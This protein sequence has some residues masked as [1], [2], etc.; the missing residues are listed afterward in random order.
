MQA[1]T[2]SLYISEPLA[3]QRSLV[4]DNCKQC[5]LCVKECRFLSEYGNPAQIAASYSEMQ[6][7][8]AFEC[9][10]C[11][12]CTAVCP[13]DV[14]P[15]KMFLEMRRETTR[16][17]GGIPPTYKIIRNYEKRG[18]SPRFSYYGLPEGCNTIFF[19]GCSLPGTR[20]DK[21]I[22]LFQYLQ[23]RTPGIGIVLDCCTK[24][25]HDL[26]DE[27]FFENMF[28][29]L[30]RYLLDHNIS[31]VIVACTNCY[32]VFKNYGDEL[33]VISAYE[34]LDRDFLPPVINNKAPITIHDPCAVRFDATIHTAVRSL[35]K[36]TGLEVQEMEHTRENTI[37]CGEGGAVGFLKP[38]FAQTWSGMRKREANGRTIL[39]YCAGCTSYLNPLTPTSHLLDLL[40]EPG[41]TMAGK[42]KVSRT[43]FTY[44]NR[45][46]VK[47]YF[48]NTLETKATRER[49]LSIQQTEKKKGGRL[50]QLGLLALLALAIVAIRVTGVDSYFDQE[51]LQHLI[52]GYGALG[53]IVFMTLYAIAPSLFLPG[54]PFAVVAGVLFGPFW[55]IVYA[56]CGATAGATLAFLIGRYAGRQW[57]ENKLTGPT[58]QQLDRD[59]ERLG[60][61]MV[62]FTRLIP[63]FP[64]N[65]LNYAFGLTKIKLLHYVV[66]SF[67][68]MLPGCVAYILLSSSLLDVLKGSV[69]PVF[70]SGVAAMALLSAVPFMYKRYKQRA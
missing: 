1:D 22:K 69:S 67:L 13:F 21:V 32:K 30:K 18:I 56:I 58:W 2:A 14:D 10:L 34:E 68:F 63:L 43:P 3:R 50:Q 16:Q 20:P 38:E 59:V 26:G 15:V 36:K 27:S 66:A 51:R 40:F 53:P 70:I 55:G 5:G 7:F 39:T 42:A 25:T 37:C 35:I 46:K 61:K 62:A 12:L 9:S 41:Q 31:K 49:P 44:L 33:T 45:L 64:F 8:S 54:L 52:Q 4:V 47:K 19:P 17:S 24:P 11:H 60:W 65:L 28:D 29:D 57:L 48:R 6:H 23:K